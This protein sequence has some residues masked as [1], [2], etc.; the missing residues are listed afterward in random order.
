M[1][2]QIQKRNR[3]KRIITLIFFTV[4]ILRAKNTSRSLEKKTKKNQRY[5]KKY[6][7]KQD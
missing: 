4:S 1:R 2:G 5:R 7:D 3:F 6:L